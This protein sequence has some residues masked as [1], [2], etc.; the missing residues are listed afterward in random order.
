MLPLGLEQ[1]EV[2]QFLFAHF[3]IAVGLTEKCLVLESCRAVLE[4]KTLNFRDDNVTLRKRKR[5]EIYHDRGFN[6]IP[7]ETCHAGLEVSNFSSNSGDLKA[8]AFCNSD[9]DGSASWHVAKGAQG[10]SEFRESVGSGFYL[11][12][13]PVSAACSKLLEQLL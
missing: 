13:G 5:V 1:L 11:D 6:V 2:L 3:V 10:V 4:R 7:G 12:I 8:L 9:D